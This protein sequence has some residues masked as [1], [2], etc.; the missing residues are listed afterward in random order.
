MP[1]KL[2]VLGAGGRMGRAVLEASERFDFESVTSIIRGD[3]AEAA[4]ATC[5]IA[6]DFSSKEA[7]GEFLKLASKYK[8][9]IVIGTTG[10]DEVFFN[11]LRDYS[12]LIPIVYAPNFSI[13]INLLYYISKK[14][15]TALK[16]KPFN[17]SIKETHHIHKKDSPSGT[18]LRL[19]E[20]LG[21][22]VAIEARREGEVF[23]DHGVIFES[24]GEKLEL[25]HSAKSRQPFAEGALTAAKWLLEGKSAGLYSML[26]V[27]ELNF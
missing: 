20:V 5:D 14:T 6:I 16:N 19:K 3:S 21:G 11:K 2:A 26:D 13:G 8:K 18:A 9:P 27:L 12:K 4:F 1:K 17:V 7:S 24:F 15:Q 10:H 25:K 23:G 22:D